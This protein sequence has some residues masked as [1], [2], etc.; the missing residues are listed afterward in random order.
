MTRGY[1]NEEIKSQLINLLHDSK[2][3]LSG[4]EIS[5]KLGINR[6]TMTKFLNVFAA[7]GIIIQK[8]IGNIN[9]WLVED[10]TEQFQFPA[11]YFKVQEKYLK[12][13]T[14]C[15]E[16]AIYN[17]IRNCINSKV[18]I[19]KLMIEVIIPSIIETQKSFNDGKIGKSEQQ[20]MTG[21]ISNSIQMITHHSGQSESGKNVMILSADPESLLTSDAAGAAFRSQ[22]WNVFSIGDISSS[23]DVL[24]DLELRKILSKTWKSKT[25]IMMILVFSQT[26][27]GLKFISDSFYSVKE[28]SEKNLFIILSGKIGKKVKIKADLLT[29]KFEDIIQWSNTKYE[30]L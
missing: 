8:N 29:S 25:G 15:H 7:E 13:L 21:I 11:D 17:L 27:E 2:T 30:N 1:N 24:F 6:V 16:S 28:K 22:N 20:L 18:S 12:L 19:T 23:I 9:L 5:T 3:G 4:V 10:D 26:E 14:E